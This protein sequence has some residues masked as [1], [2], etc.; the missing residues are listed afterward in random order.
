MPHAPRDVIVAMT[1]LPREGRNKTRL[2]P[3]LGPL[4]AT[5]FHERLARH[6]IGRASS[7]ALTNPE[8]SLR[9]HLEG[10]TAPQGR[11]WLGGGDCR[12]Q[13]EGDL[14]DRLF[15]AVD[16]AFADGARRV[17]VI[18]TDCPTLDESVF[19]EAFTVLDE[20]DMVFGPAADGGYYLVGLSRPC[21]AIFSDIEWGGEKVLEQSVAAARSVGREPALLE[22]LSDVDTPDDLPA[23]ETALDQGSSVS[24]VIPTLNE[25]AC[26][27]S[28]LDVLLRVGPHEVIIADGDSSDRTLAVA[29]EAGAKIVSA[30]RGRAAQMNHGAAVATGEHLL[31][32]HADTVPP[33][34]YEAVINRILGVPGTAVGAFRFELD[35]DLPAAPLIES[36]VSLRC[37]L[38]GT[39]YGDQGLFVRRHVFDHLGGFPEWPAMEDVDFVRRLK[40]MGKVRI[41]DESARTSARRWRNQ[42]VIRT[43]LGHQLMLASY[44]VG[45]SPRQI[46]KLRP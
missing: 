23:A 9:I 40:R 24:V 6:A 10:G 15:A 19:G 42:G 44:R 35:S 28:L 38:Q 27:G 14:G 30:P 17:V 36:L 8:A 5:A 11:D 46:A 29:E 1:R 31:F 22:V 21:R 37:Q 25:E 20:S 33:A 26:L 3:A 2:I 4:G 7:Y 13:D 45:L 41:S 32:L 34:S 18:G 43:F 39:P 16:E 12:I